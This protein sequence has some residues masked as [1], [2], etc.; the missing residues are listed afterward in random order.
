MS[1]KDYQAQP[2]TEGKGNLLF[3]LFFGTT[4][5]TEE[6]SAV[7]AETQFKPWNPDDL[8]QKSGNYC[9]Y[10]DMMDDDQISVLV[11]LKKS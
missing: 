5:K 4:E 1:K 6:E 3:N 10:E 7:V 2:K 11:Q 9:I 8:W